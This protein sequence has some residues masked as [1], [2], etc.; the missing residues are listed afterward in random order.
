MPGKDST[1]RRKFL[2]QIGSA[3]ILAAA[4]PLANFDAKEKAEERMIRYEK[5]ITANDKVRV[6][7]MATASRD[8][9]TWPLH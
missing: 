8:I 6:A 3:S 7:V 4:G 5:K 2:Q 9:L 1:S